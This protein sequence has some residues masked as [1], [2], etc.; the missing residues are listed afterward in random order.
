MQYIPMCVLTVQYAYVHGLWCYVLCAI[1]I[2]T[3]LC[4]VIVI[5]IN[6][7]RYDGCYA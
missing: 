7:Q 3:V 4:V 5:N 6:V 1:V 2:V